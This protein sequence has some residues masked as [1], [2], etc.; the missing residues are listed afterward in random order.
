MLTLRPILPALAL[1]AS[2]AQAAPLYRVVALATPPGV[3]V[4]NTAA[5]LSFWRV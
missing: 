1:A 5:G 3:V 2:L 4:S